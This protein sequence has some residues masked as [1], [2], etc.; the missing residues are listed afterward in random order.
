MD[1]NSNSYTFIYASVM[2]IVVA[3]VLALAA[4]NLKPYQEK[5]VAIEKKQNILKSV[6]IV[7]DAAHAE[8]KYSDVITDAFVVNNQG[9]KVDGDAFT[10][11]LKAQY[12]E[13]DASKKLLPVF[14]AKTDKGTKYIIPLYGAGL[15]GPI[16]GYISLNED[17][18][19]IYGAT[20]DHQGET[21]GLGAEIA[22]SGFQKPFV[23]KTIFD[24]SGK[25]VS[26]T[27]AKASEKATANPAHSVD[28]ISGGTITSKGLQAMVGDDLKLYENFIKKVK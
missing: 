18:S 3:A 23:G 8:D 17:M 1:K 25:L 15:W 28:A 26:I 4:V 13:R 16:W 14:V 2:V 24:K 12:S 21:P 22:T 6:N 7:V 27:V 11:N 20:F 9:E 5:N 10:V 19:T